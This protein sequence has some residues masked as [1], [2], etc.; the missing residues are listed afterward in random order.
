MSDGTVFVGREDELK[1]W[2]EVLASPDGQ[3]VLVVGQEGMG[4]TLL[5]N[6]MVDMAMK[7]P[8]LKC[9][10]VRYE[11]TRTD[12]V[13]GILATMITQTYQA[14]HLTE[15]SFSGT[16]KRREQLRAFLNVFKVGDLWMSLHSQDE[17]SVRDQFIGTL[18]R[19]SSR[20]PENGRGLFIIDPEKYVEEGSDQAWAIVIRELPA[21]IKLLFAQRPEDA[22]ASS[23]VFRALKNLVRIPEDHLSVLEDDAVDELIRRRLGNT[24]IS[25]SGVREALHRYDGHPYAVD[26]ALGLIA[27]GVPLGE[28]P[29][30]PTGIAA[31]QWKRICQHDP[32]AIRLFEAYAILEVPV[33]DEVVEAVSGLSRPERLSV[34]ADPLLAGLLRDEPDG[35]R[36]YHTLLA[37]HMRGQLSDSDAK[38]YHQR[39]AETYRKGLHAGEKADALA[40]LRLP[41]HVLAAEGEG[42]FVACFIEECTEP[43]LTLGLLDAALDFSERALG[44]VSDGSVREAMMLGNLGLIYRRRGELGRAEEMHR[45][46][47]DI[48]ENLGNQEGMAKQYGNLG[49][50]YLTRGE[51]DK[52]EEMHLKSL[53][54]EKGLGRLEG[55]A[56]EYGNLGLVYRER[57]KLGRAEQM[58]RKSLEVHQRIGNKQGIGKQYGNLGLIYRK[59][60]KLDRAEE[61]HRES[62]DIAEELG[63]LDTVAAAYSNLGLIYKKRG[64]LCSAEGMHRKSLD[65]AEKSGNREVMAKEYG[66]LGAICEKRGDAAGARHYWIK[67]RDLFQRIG[68]PQMVQK[69]QRSIDDLPDAGEEE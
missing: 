66:N 36:I 33:P 17:T 42:A 13:E 19:V 8:D 15:D 54:I 7:H 65:I 27:D 41:E 3:A 63:D 34:V 43:L 64:D 1:Q 62:L 38:P 46:S 2:A 48:A 56:A 11:V 61:M 31:A 32:A 22:L 69:A 67:A 18:E 14:A 44:M 4:K 57:G 52:A 21:K 16:K 9:G 6:R 37:D 10:A 45:K 53:E 68:M 28:L 60:G 39:A 25:L 20:M 26:A 51:F 58:H 29:S 23:D 24:G 55:M 50:I 40:A 49:L 5:L 35:P 30:D 59:R 47:L 12:S